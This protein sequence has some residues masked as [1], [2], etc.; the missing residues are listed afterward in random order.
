VFEITVDTLALV[1]VGVALAWRQYWRE[2]VPVTA[3]RAS[4]WTRAARAD[5]YQ[6]VVNAS[7]FERPGLYLTRSLV[8]VDG[9]GVD[10]SV[11]GTAR[12][13]RGLGAWL[14]R[15]QNGFVRTYAAT[16][17]IGV[18]LLLGSLLVVR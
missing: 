5:L 2:E 3:P 1:A 17:L 14:R 12:L 18:V 7:V 11:V 6:E 9:R 8:F 16:M 10:G 15:F 4:L 13:V